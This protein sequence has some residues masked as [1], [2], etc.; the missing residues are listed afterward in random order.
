[1]FGSFKFVQGGGYVIAVAMAIP[2]AAFLV[3][4]VRGLL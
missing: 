3:S 1:M 2:T 4:L